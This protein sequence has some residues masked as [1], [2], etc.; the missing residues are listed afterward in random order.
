MKR[1]RLRPAFIESAAWGDKK[2]CPACGKEIR[3]EAL[4]CRHCGAAFETRAPLSKQQYVEREYSEKEY[5]RA[6]NQLVALF[7]VS[8]TGCLAPLGL[9]LSGVLISKG[10][11]QDIHF[12]RLPPA[13]R[14]LAICTAALS[15]LLTLLLLLFVTLDSG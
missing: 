13:L 2:N 8:A 5:M 7:L 6:R 14:A 3:G 11:L 12:K 10:H 15:G 1:P 9:I 4:K